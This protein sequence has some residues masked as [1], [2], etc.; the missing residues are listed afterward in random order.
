VLPP[1]AASTLYRT[2]G[3]SLVVV[4]GPGNGSA[5]LSA[6]V[7]LMSDAAREPCRRLVLDVGNVHRMSSDLLALL[8]W[9][10]VRLRAR[11]SHLAVARPTAATRELLRRTGLDHVLPVLDRL[12]EEV[13]A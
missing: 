6:A 13:A 10:N 1:S 4:I 7:S 12:P 9:A 2:D 5:Q 3:D 8:L 11:G